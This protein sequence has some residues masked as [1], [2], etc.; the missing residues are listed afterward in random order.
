MVRIGTRDALQHADL[1]VGLVVAI[2][3]LEMPDL[4]RRRYQHPAAPEL[5]AGDAVELVSED[6]ELVGLAV[7]VFIRQDHQRIPGR[8]GRVPVRIGRP[9]R[10]P[11]TA[12]GIN[13]HLHG[14]DEPGELLL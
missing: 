13:G 11:Q 3:I 2:G 14:V 1:D 8:I 7:A 12:V 4:R 6:D 10:H 9:D 5:E